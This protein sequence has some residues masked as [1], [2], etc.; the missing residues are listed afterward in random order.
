MLKDVVDSLLCEV[1]KLRLAVLQKFLSVKLQVS[2]EEI[3]RPLH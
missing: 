1:F 2:L 3:H